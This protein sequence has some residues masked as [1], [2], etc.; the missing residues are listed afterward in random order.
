MAEATRT[1]IEISASA[2]RHNVNVLAKLAGDSSKLMPIVKSDAYG[3]GL[4]HAVSVLK[5][6]KIWGLGVAY[7]SE[8]NNA[9]RLGWQGKIAVLSHWSPQELPI[10]AKNE[11]EIVIW[12]WKSLIL[13]NN[14]GSFKKP[15]RCHLKLDTGTSRIGFLPTDLYKLG[16]FLKQ[17]RFILLSGVFSHLANAEE[18]TTARTNKQIQSFTTLVASLNV[19]NGGLHLACS[20]ALIRYPASRFDLSRPGIALY[21]LWPSP[22]IKSWARI[23]KPRIS[24]SPVLSWYTRIMQ[25]KT[26]PAKTCVGYG[27]THTAKRQSIIAIIPV[28]YADGYDRR[29]SNCG[30]VSIHGRRAPIIGRVCMNLTMIDVTELTMAKVGDVVTLV[31]DHVKLDDLAERGKI[32]NYE[33]VS[34]IHPAITRKLSA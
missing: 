30:W 5:K 19:P 31:G 2:L 17:S 15:L 4:E 18:K 25:I 11:V 1:W 23:N 3:H 14:Y 10:L 8:A 7:G 9:R 24:L 13:A 28:G 26:V 6:A 22:E 32:L 33:L 21:G 20:A 12:D 27:S 29:L 16:K 34:R